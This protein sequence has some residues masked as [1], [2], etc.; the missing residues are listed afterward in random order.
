[1][2]EDTEP[3]YLATAELLDWSAGDT[4][5][6]YAFKVVRAI[7][8]DAL[9]TELAALKPRRCS[10]DM[11]S[12]PPRDCDAPYC[13]CNPAWLQCMEM[14]QEIG[15]QTP[16]E[17]RSI[18]ARIR[19]LEAELEIGVNLL[20]LI[21]VPYSHKSLRDDIQKF[22][23]GYPAA[24]KHEPHIRHHDTECTCACG[25]PWPCPQSLPE[26]R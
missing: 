10:A 22:L 24:V 21:Y 6:I 26:T 7:R 2:S 5:E 25:G 23:C 4:D 17:V 3:L 16:D 15:W 12:D 9:V 18:E 14:L 8:Y 13:G 19:E 20:R 1:M 11:Y